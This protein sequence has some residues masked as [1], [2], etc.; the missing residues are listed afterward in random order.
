M[1][2]FWE[3]LVTDGRT[4]ESDFIGP[5]PTNVERPIKKY[6]LKC[7]PSATQPLPIFKS[8]PIK[9]VW[10]GSKYASAL[11]KKTGVLKISENSR[12]SGWVEA[13]LNKA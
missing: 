11:K 2:Q 9:H 12:N 6:V 13:H 10:Q 8:L 7:L 3:N 5:C 4:D 1:I